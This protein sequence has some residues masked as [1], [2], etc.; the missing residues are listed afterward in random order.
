MS[1]SK[2]R[3]PA[4]SFLNQV[5]GWMRM[6]SAEHWGVSL[7]LILSFA[8]ETVGFLTTFV[9]P[10]RRVCQEECQLT[11]WSAWIRTYYW[12]MLDGV[13]RGFWFP[14]SGE[15]LTCGWLWTAWCIYVSASETTGKIRKIGK[16]GNISFWT[17][18][19]RLPVATR[20]HTHT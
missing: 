11:R 20:G 18:I 5:K 8:W 6:A 14:D 10:P 13:I 12:V 16:I 3:A 17:F 2:T 19:Q 15:R 9:A 7:L 4:K 1:T